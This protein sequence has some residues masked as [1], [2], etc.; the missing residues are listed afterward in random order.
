MQYETKSD[1]GASYTATFTG[2]I[3][4]FTRV[5]NQPEPFGESERLDVKFRIELN[6]PETISGNED[7]VL[8]QLNDDLGQTNIDLKVEARGPTRISEEV[9]Q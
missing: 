4:E 1:S 5:T 7:D 8:A 3:D 9:D 2:G 6:E